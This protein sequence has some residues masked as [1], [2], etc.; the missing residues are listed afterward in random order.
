MTSPLWL[1][2]R[3]PNTAGSDASL[4]KDSPK[5]L[6]LQKLF[7]RLTN[8]KFMY[9]FCEMI[10]EA[11]ESM[12]PAPET[13][14]GFTNSALV[15]RPLA[16]AQA[17]WSLELAADE[18]GEGH[19]TE[20]EDSDSEDPNPRG[21]PFKIKIGGKQ[22]GFDGPLGLKLGK[23]YSDYLPK[24]QE[25]P[26]KDDDGT[27]VIT[28]TKPFVLRPFFPS[29]E[30]SSSAAD[31]AEKRNR[32][33]CVRSVL[34]DPFSPI[35]A[36]SGLL[37]VRELILPSWTWQA[38]LSR[39][40]AFFHAGPIVMA[41][42]VPSTLNRNRGLTAEDPLTESSHFKLAEGPVRLSEPGQGDWDWLQPYNPD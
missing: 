24:D 25:L 31:F 13:F 2:F 39:M 14:V 6:Q 23:V 21:Y 20:D 22:K 4:S 19:E 3:P 26:I 42:D 28:P 1:P 8:V 11:T 33:L 12:Q 34:V 15:G 10:K 16:L 35:H 37:P 41:K 9:A 17:G 18:P 40:N 5:T 27:E 30:L 36:Y 38:A 7:E 29:R 32:H